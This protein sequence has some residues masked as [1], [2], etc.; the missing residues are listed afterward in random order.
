MSSATDRVKFLADRR[1]G[2]GGSDA[3]GACGMS[4]WVTRLDIYI[5]KI[6]EGVD[7]ET[8]DMR[9]GTLLEPV[10]RQMY[11]D[12]TGHAVVTPG[13]IIRNEK[14]PFAHAN[15]DGLTSGQ[16]VVFEGKTSRERSGWG[17]EWSSDIP[18]DYFFQVQHYM[19][20]C[21]LELAH[22]AVMFGMGF[23]FAI[24]EVEA[25][26][27]F[28]G[29]MMEQEREF[30]EMVTNRTPPEPTTPADISRRWPM[31][32]AIGKAASKN[33]LN[34]AAKLSAVKDYKSK[35][36]DYQEHLESE[37]KR[38]MEEHDTLTYGGEVVA[39]WKTAQGAKRFDAKQLKAEKPELHKQY[40]YQS[41]P[42]RRFLLKGNSI[43]LQNMKPLLHENLLAHQE[44]TQDS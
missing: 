23:Q 19:A 20:V 29:M 18:I 36:D 25:D 13:E 6:G 4:K 41:A 35:L 39:T 5:D 38:S 31:S 24:Y 12:E 33:D 17:D 8:P 11:A 26:E 1:A 2:L 42:S 27:E 10:V 30:W 3:A 9:R 43:C 22:V 34:V 44:E 14:L 32:K 16:T 7:I 21:E 40:S 15:L 28:Q 37:L